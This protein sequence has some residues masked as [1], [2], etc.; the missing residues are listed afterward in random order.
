MSVEF[1]DTNV[2]VYAHDTSAGDKRLR[3]AE[4]VIR[5][6]RS[7]TGCVSVQVLMELAATLTRKVDPP[8]SA[9]SA[10]EIVDDLA[11]WAVYEPTGADVGAALRIAERHTISIW[12]AMIVHAAASMQADVLWTE[13][14]NHG[15]TYEGVP[16]RNPF[17]DG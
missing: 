17:R 1:V 10:A 2:L 11:T 8:L 4:L 6:G 14:L 7:G 12:D 9:G 5:L 15:Q 3:A 16:V 13:D